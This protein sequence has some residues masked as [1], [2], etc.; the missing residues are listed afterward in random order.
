MR[1]ENNLELNK[2]FQKIDYSKQNP[3][4]EEAFVNLG[5]N[6]LETI[7]KK[8]WYFTLAEK[9]SQIPEEQQKSITLIL[10]NYLA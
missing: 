9:I 1:V 3:S 10:D 5:W 8:E 4:L 2:N 6:T 7:E